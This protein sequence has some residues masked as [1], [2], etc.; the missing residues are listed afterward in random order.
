VVA[1]HGEGWFTVSGRG[2]GEG[3]GTQSVVAGSGEEVG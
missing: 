1:G 3:G 2:P